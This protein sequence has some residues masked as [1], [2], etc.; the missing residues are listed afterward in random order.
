MPHRA[1]AATLKT[2]QQQKKT[3]G[4]ISV[5]G[6]SMAEDLIFTELAR[7]S[8]CSFLRDVKLVLGKGHT[9]QNTFEVCGAGGD[10]C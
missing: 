2:P 8:L 5:Q 4:K 1:L 10:L 3:E 7:G 9:V 6:K